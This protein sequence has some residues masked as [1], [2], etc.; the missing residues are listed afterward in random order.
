MKNW[1][2]TAYA[3]DCAGGA[4]WIGAGAG[5][6]TYVG[7]AAGAG[8]DGAAGGCCCRAS[9][10]LR[11]P[12]SAT[13]ATTATTTPANRNAFMVALPLVDGRLARPARITP[14]SV[15]GP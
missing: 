9:A 14:R 1:V 15:A 8:P 10:G 3:N 13:T 11:L 7:G 4:Y 2:A 6:S 5:W 12:I